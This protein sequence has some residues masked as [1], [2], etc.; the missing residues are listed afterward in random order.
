[1]CR[2]RHTQKC[3]SSYFAWFGLNG[4]LVLTL[5]MSL[6]A[7]V[8]AAIRLAGDKTRKYAYFCAAAML[9]S[10]LGDI[11]LMHLDFIE[12]NLPNYFIWGAACFMVAH[13]LYTLAF[14][15]LGRSKGYRYFNGGVIAAI[16]IALAC[17]VYFT[18]ICAQRQ[19][20]SM[21]ALCMIYLAVIGTNCATIFSYAWSSFQKKPYL[22]MCAVGALSFF[23][24]D[25]IIG[26]DILA[27]ISDFGHL[28]WWY[29]PIGQILLH[30]FAF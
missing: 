4:S 25:L 18:V 19:D 2:V 6:L 16:V 5:L 7:I 22:V 21:Y 27:G 10:S 12:Q 14:L 24:S 29:Y 11:F 20:F 15:K 28:I 1:M 8:L 9:M 30:V 17:L 26:L 3:M 23:I 13:V